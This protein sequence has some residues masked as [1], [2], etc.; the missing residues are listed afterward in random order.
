MEDP[1]G[2]KG[3]DVL[4]VLIGHYP[5]AQKTTVDVFRLSVSE[6]DPHP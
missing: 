1:F 2:A 6:A 3:V 4:L 5:S